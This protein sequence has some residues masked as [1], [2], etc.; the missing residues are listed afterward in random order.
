M[1]E[2]LSELSGETATYLARLAISIG[3]GFLIGMERTFSKKQKAEEEEFAGLRTHT[4]I[5]MFGFLAALVAQ[6]TGL[7]F[8]GIAFAGMMAFV[9]ISYMRL[10]VRTGNAGGTSEVATILT[11][12]LGAMV[13]YGQILLALVVVVVVLLL[14]T[15]KPSLHLFV[16]KLSQEE[17]RAIIQFVI[18]S[19]LV[20]PSLPN[21]NFGPYSLW[22]LK[23]I[24]KM[25]I[26]VSGTSL[27]GY[28]V[29]KLVG[30]KGTMLAG[31]VGGL[32]SS[33]AVTLTFSR[34]SKL[35]SGGAET[36]SFY[37]AMAIISACTIMFP[38]I[39]FE[40][41]VVNRNLAQQ[42]WIPIAAITLAG[43]GAAFYIYKKRKGKKEETSLPLKNPLN[44]GTAIKFALFFAGVMLLVKY[45]S[46]NFGDEGTYIAGAISGI[47]D[48]D[49]ITL[50]MAKTA[51]A[52][53]TYPLAINTILLAA[54]SNTL[55][56][57]CL[58][59]A[60][61]S[62]SLLKTAAIGFAAV[63]LTGLGFFLF[64]LLR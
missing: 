33:T 42:L 41:L 8:L 38:R 12:L 53:E 56:K 26:L 22:N 10:S 51:T 52:P 24:W 50:S 28:L 17:L 14:L 31:M 44:F 34:R 19:A 21:S 55:V 6:L 45:S 48:V 64:Y 32:V 59:M 27:I 37:Y 61:G 49:A 36:G 57:F 35:G 9:I 4:L 58:V 39:L 5:A 7:W 13:F 3:I 18:I 15:Y 47:T 1:D 2:Q 11:F 54:L 60:L 43:F 25:V 40:V 46:E 29:A 62:K 20:I 30:N 63:F 16:Q 23:D